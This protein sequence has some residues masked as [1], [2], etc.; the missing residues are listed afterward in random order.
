VKGFVWYFSVSSIEEAVNLLGI[1]QNKQALFFYGWNESTICLP[2]QMTEEHWAELGK[3][4][5]SC[6]IFGP[7]CE[8]RCRFLSNAYHCWIS[9]EIPWEELKQGSS[10]TP[11]PLETSVFDIVKDGIRILWGRKLRIQSDERRGEV[12]FPRFLEYFAQDDLE[13]AVIIRVKK[14]QHSSLGKVWVRYQGLDL[15]PVSKWADY[16]VEPLTTCTS[17]ES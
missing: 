1:R 8:I 12:A 13:S 11:E 2:Q 9:A 5:D 16:E 7:A 14:Y 10:G 17:D 4:W 6:C 3:N 15:L